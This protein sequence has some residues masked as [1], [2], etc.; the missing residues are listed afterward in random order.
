MSCL[1]PCVP[2]TWKKEDSFWNHAAGNFVQLT[3]SYIVIQNFGGVSC[4]S[5]TQKYVRI[6]QHNESNV[7]QKKIHYDI[8]LFM[9]FCVYVSCDV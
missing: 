1:D 2:E 3:P 9:F 6:R 7:M 8:D 5:S 4:A